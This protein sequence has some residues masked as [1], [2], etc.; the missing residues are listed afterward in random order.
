MKHSQAKRVFSFLLAA[1]MVLTMTSIMASAKWSYTKPYYVQEGKPV[2]S[3]GQCA[4]MICDML[5]DVLLSLGLKIDKITIPGWVAWIVGGGG[6]DVV[7]WLDLTNIDTMAES[8]NATLGPGTKGAVDTLLGLGDL[9]AI[10]TDALATIASRFKRNE[11]GAYPNAG[12]SVER[13]GLRDL[14]VLQL[15]FQF[16]YDNRG[17]LS[18]LVGS[19]NKGT[20]Y[21]G[22]FSFGGLPGFL[23]NEG[24][25]GTIAGWAGLTGMEEI[26][27]MM[28]QM[29]KDFVGWLMG[30]LVPSLGLDLDLSN[31]WDA[32]LSAMLKDL[33]GPL[34]EGLLPGLELNIDLF[35]TS[36]FDML[37]N[38]VNSV[39]EG[40]IPMLIDLLAPMMG[41]A[42]PDAA[43]PGGYFDENLKGYDPLI[44][45][46]LWAPL[47]VGGP[48]LLAGLL[49]EEPIP[50]SMSPGDSP[51]ECPAPYLML[52]ES[53][54]WILLR[55]VNGTSFLD[56]FLWRNYPDA[57]G[58]VAPPARRIGL[59]IK[60]KPPGSKYK[61]ALSDWL[62]TLIDDKL[63][64]ILSMLG[65][66]IDIDVDAIRDFDLPTK[67]AF[68]LKGL[69]PM[70]MDY[71]Y[72]PDE[73]E[74]LR[75]VATFILVDMM[76]DIVP[77]KMYDLTS[78]YFRAE[79][80]KNKPGFNKDQLSTGKQLNPY[81][82]GVYVVLGDL[83]RYYLNPM[84]P[85]LNLP[86]NK[87]FDGLIS[88]LTAWIFGSYGG[89]LRAP[90][91]SD[92]DGWGRLSYLL[93]GSNTPGDHTND[94]ILRLDWFD[95]AIVSAGGERVLR[96]LAIDRLLE[97]I[98]GLEFKKVFSLFSAS[99]E[100]N[101][102]P[103]RIVLRVIARL[104][105]SVLKVPSGDSCID[106]NL[107][108][109]DAL[110]SG[111]GMGRLIFYFCR[112]LGDPTVSSNLLT[113]LPLLAGL[114]GL[115]N[116]GDFM[117]HLVT[118]EEVNEKPFLA[119]VDAVDVRSIADF[120]KLLN[121]I[122]PLDQAG[123]EW[124]VLPV[125]SNP[126]SK[127]Y[128]HHYG[129]ENFMLEDQYRYNF[130]K[131]IRDEA[132]SVLNRM[133]EGDPELT[134]YQ[135]SNTY[136]KLAFYT[137]NSWNPLIN[138]K[139]RYDPEPAKDSIRSD[140]YLGYGGL[141]FQHL[142]YTF[143]R[144][145]K[146]G[147]EAENYTR[148]SWTVYKRAHTFARALLDRYYD[149]KLKGITQAA[150]TR[151]RHELIIAERQ[152]QKI[153]GLASFVEFD[154]VMANLVEPAVINRLFYFSGDPAVAGSIEYL[155]DQVN[156]SGLYYEALA[157]SADRGAYDE[158]AQNLVND[159]VAKLRDAV[160]KLLPKNLLA[161]KGV[162]RLYYG[163]STPLP[164]DV[165]AGVVD[166]KIL[167]NLPYGLTIT[168][169]NY[170][171]VNYLMN[172]K[173]PGTTL[174]WTE[175]IQTKMMYSLRY[176]GTG[177]TFKII[178]TGVALD[179]VVVLIFG[180]LMGAANTAGAL[181]QRGDSFVTGLDVQMLDRYLD[182]KSAD[183]SDI[184]KT[185]ADVNHSG[186]WASE[187]TPEDRDLLFK[188][189]MGLYDIEQGNFNW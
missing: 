37:R 164:G 135:I 36:A 183:L 87:T 47:V 173:N 5:D 149:V 155:V 138:G 167:Y 9:N 115:W 41:V 141:E 48:G 88:A 58:Y 181:V 95:S 24:I 51:E 130:Y 134:Q 113:V 21:S 162:A 91:T 169:S 180:D 60:D 69:L 108:S 7:V 106:L 56:K 13:D 66:G 1:L 99:G 124:D 3:T 182:G 82:D 11:V 94:G 127:V 111:K 140:E 19:N 145:S 96:Y 186:G 64:N 75:E 158:G 93:L 154:I 22:Q 20:S 16:L 132:I 39:L 90:I 112:Q 116:E 146:K 166:W 61:D 123:V 175:Q 172:F 62:G 174:S 133:K 147:Y 101:E 142:R 84:M 177:S 46:I 109:L 110:L 187:P 152:L 77:E 189:T 30:M 43:H 63:A 119:P 14:Y 98:L 156:K 17:M 117:P 81:T 80:N 85:S 160:E 68:I 23:R 171:V 161:P 163:V 27:G 102:P 15:L 120:E 86:E 8:L 72:V 121:S 52:K 55:G 168:G 40:A 122:Q 12:T 29:S 179:A 74:T 159:M 92:D 129:P 157:M 26:A 54:E 33:L 35:S 83:L 148:A 97:G 153:T 137:D 76:S 70:F 50:H 32:A 107:N 44:G 125:S 4:T 31:G 53:F 136:A 89:L 131:D 178:S 45:G 34:L 59:T 150:I 126:A 42:P 28:D 114:M 176:I 10:N 6:S 165:H 103:M 144:I 105:N 170:P 65:L 184:Q 73:A 2:M 100:L 118:Q 185:A 104:L 38:L 57:P 78:R 71:V 67:V 128:Y 139:Y 79:E 25:W 188:A 143:E 18:K 49:S 151:A